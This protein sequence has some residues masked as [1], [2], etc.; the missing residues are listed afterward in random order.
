V[1]ARDRRQPV[2]GRSVGNLRRRTERVDRGFTIETSPD[3]NT[4]TTVATGT[5]TN[6]DDGQFNEVDPTTT[7][8]GVNYVRFTFTSNQT[9]S[10]A[11]NCPG[12]AFAGCSFTDLTELEV[13]GAQ[14]L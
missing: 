4:Y 5:F 14:S 12:G 6:A 10:F 7:A 13:F 2:R 1:P 8:D 9:P 3:G 11:T